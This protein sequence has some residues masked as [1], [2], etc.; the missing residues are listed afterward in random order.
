[1][2]RALLCCPSINEKIDVTCGLRSLRNYALARPDLRERLEIEIVP[3]SVDE[4]AAGAAEKL[5]ERS[6]DLV[7]LSTFIWNVGDN[8]GL[9]REIKRRSPETG[10]ILGGPQVS[11]PL[12]DVLGLDE[13]ASPVDLVVRGEGEETFSEV[14]RS[15]LD[16][17]RLA[18]PGIAGTSYR[19]DDGGTVH[20]PDRP[21]IADLDEIPPIYD[22]FE[23]QPD[24]LYGLETARGCYHRCGYC[25]MGLLPFRRHSVEYVLA[26]IDHMAQAGVRVL[27]S[28]DSSF[29]FNPRRTELLAR[30][31]QQHGIRYICCAKAEEMRGGTADLLVETGVLKIEFGIQSTHPE[32]LRLMGRPTRLDLLGRRVLGMLDRTRGTDIEV[33]LDV[34]CGL[35]GDDLEA[36][37]DSLDF[38]YSLRPHCVAAFPLQLLPATDLFRR[39]GELGIRYRPMRPDFHNHDRYSLHKYGLVTETATFPTRELELGRRIC[40][41]NGLILQG[42]LTGLVHR[43]LDLEGLRFST[44]LDRLAGHLPGDIYDLLDTLHGDPSRK[45]QVWQ[46]VVRAFAGYAGTARPEVA[47]AIGEV[48]PLARLSA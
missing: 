22:G 26:E 10:V 13:A 19:G 41:L 14:L 40:L 37:R 24:V 23:A 43:I 35:P 6:A 1:M 2:K 44:W 28:L 4:P 46:L 7:G 42:H 15:W 36:F 45:R 8:L 30:R 11:D 29:T 5:L 12:W 27:N 20:A 34:I 16:T 47:Q 32:T 25:M 9:A 39:A 21:L 3:L 18:S 48:F 38:A 31:L 17:G 33:T